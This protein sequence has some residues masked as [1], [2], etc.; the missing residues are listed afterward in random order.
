MSITDGKRIEQ[1]ILVENK[2]ENVPLQHASIKFN[3]SYGQKWKKT[4]IEY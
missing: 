3:K 4:K 2:S 1:K